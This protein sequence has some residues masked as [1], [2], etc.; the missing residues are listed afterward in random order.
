[1]NKVD[2]IYSFVYLAIGFLF[3]ELFMFQ[4]Y[5]MKFRIE[6]PVFC[7]FY[8]AATLSYARTKNVSLSKETVF[9]MIITMVICT[10]VCRVNPQVA[11][12]PRI[13]CAA[14][15]TYSLGNSFTDGNGTSAY[16]IV[17]GIATMLTMPFASFFTLFRGIVTSFRLPRE[18]KDLSKALPS[19]A[20]IGMAVIA[21]YLIIPQLIQ[22]DRNFLS[23]LGRILD[24]ISDYLSRLFDNLYL[25]FRLVT[26]IPVACYLYSLIYNSLSDKKYG[27]PGREMIDEI[28]DGAKIAPAVT[29]KILLYT[30]CAV[31]ALFIFAQFRYLFGAFTGKLYEG[32]TY[33]QYAV[34]GFWELCR[35]SMINLSLMALVRFI[36]KK[37]A[38]SEVKVPMGALSVISLA[39]LGTALA[40][41]MMYISAYG[42]TE[43]R[44]I[45][46]VFLF[47]LVEVF[48]LCIFA[49]NSRFN[50][51]KIALFSLAVVFTVLFSFNLK[52]V[53][54]MYNFS[55][56]VSSLE[57]GERFST[58]VIYRAEYE[59]DSGKYIL[60]KD[61]ERYEPYADDDGTAGGRLI[62]EYVDDMTG[63]TNYVFSID[64][65][66]SRDYIVTSKAADRC[67]GGVIYKRRYCMYIPADIEPDE[68]YY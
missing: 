48:V 24:D 14:Y 13:V 3:T 45:S 8:M 38:V 4:S 36:L 55:K 46:T 11:F 30:V 60:T 41:M 43:K 67:T 49:L 25:P 47:W 31:Y 27:R 23:G 63:E 18:K 59:T 2:R 32:Y 44:I 42:L 57:P 68:K 16:I 52:D 61:G 53:S 9:W 17:D 21:L 35:V 50:L 20:G 64:G 10:R 15:Y 22:A 66:D 56:A 51:V 12:L 33:S 39:L 58:G 62:G 34:T 54:S 6:L 26:S 40:K 1:M 65:L 28:S 7:A 37:D 5:V 29:A 19:L